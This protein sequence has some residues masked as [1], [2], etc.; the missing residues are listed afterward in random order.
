MLT[1]C[2]DYVLLSP[3]FPASFQ[4]VLTSLTLV[5]PDIIYPA[6]DLLWMILG[7]ESM[8]QSAS[9]PA[10]YAQYATAIRQAASVNGFQFVGLLLTGLV[11]TF[12]EDSVHLVASLFRLLA[13]GWR[14]ELATWLPPAVQQLPAAS[15]PA[16]TK[17]KF[18]NDMGK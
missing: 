2:P 13:S 7:H 4:A 14:T 17:T 9:Q 8:T 1:F 3:S 5:H 6:L 11:T 15:L 16:D 10:K 12:P 18:L